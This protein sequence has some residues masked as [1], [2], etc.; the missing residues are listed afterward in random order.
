[1]PSARQ[2]VLEILA[3]QPE[4][5]MGL[6]ELAKEL[7]QRRVLGFGVEVWDVVDALRLRGKVD[8]DPENDIV[9]LKNS[10]DNDTSRGENKKEP[11]KIKEKK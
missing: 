7:S 3:K 9:L 1:M 2:T 8:Y 5:K 10:P 11:Q 4:K 6:T